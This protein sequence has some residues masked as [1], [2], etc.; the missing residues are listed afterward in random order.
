MFRKIYYL[1]L[2]IDGKKARRIND[3]FEKSNSAWL[4]GEFKV[5]FEDNTST[6][7][8]GERGRPPKSYEES[9]QKSKKRKNMELVQEYGFE[10]IHNAYVQYLRSIGESDEAS[11]V[12]IART[13]PKKD[14]KEVL[15]KMA[16]DRES[17][18]TY[19]KDEALRIYID[20]DL[21]KYQYGLLRSCLSEKNVFIFPSYNM[22]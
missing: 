20:L 4:D 19:S 6:T 11:I 14:K 17:V 3:R 22:I 5:T 1:N 8:S 21:T 16:Y 13:L 7:S 18:T 15:K 9:S 2:T 10:F 12:S